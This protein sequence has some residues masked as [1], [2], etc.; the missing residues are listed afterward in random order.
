[1]NMMIRRIG[2]LTL[3]ACIALAFVACKKDE[4]PK[5]VAKPAMEA[6]T[7][8]DSAA[9]REYLQALVPRTMQRPTNQPYT[10][11]LP[12]E[13]EPDFADQ[14]ERLGEKVKNDVGS[15]IIEGNMLVYASPASAKMAD[16]VVEA[17]KTVPAGTMK[18]V[19]VLFIGH[20]VDSERVKAA[21][22][23][24]GVTYVFVETK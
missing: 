23:P 11:L 1:M 22:A 15:G 14:Y 20:A 9:W 24:A 7:V 2:Q 12:G 3:I 8:D 10:Y 6:P 13:S 4:A 5:V 19:R 16:M 21:V 17:F 18:G